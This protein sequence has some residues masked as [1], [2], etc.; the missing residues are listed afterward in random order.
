MH[1]A[2]ALLSP[3]VGLGL[4]AVTG[5]ALVISARKLKPEL[6]NN[7]SL[8]ALMGVLGAFVFAAEMV[9]FSIPGT[10][11]SGHLGGAM[12]LAIIL[13]PWAGFVV[14]ASFLLIQALFFGDGGL[15]AWGANA[16]NLG[17][18]SCFV[19]YPL[20][21]RPLAGDGSQRKRVTLAVI[22][23]CTLSMA[24]AALGVTVETELSGITTIPF[25]PFMMLMVPVHLVIGLVE[26]V[27]TAAILSY[28]ARTQPDLLQRQSMP[29][30]PWRSGRTLM[31]G[32][33]LAAVLTGG[34]LTWFSSRA[35]EG[36]EWALNGMGHAKA[37]EVAA[38]DGLKSQLAHIQSSMTLFDGTPVPGGEG[39]VSPASSFEGLT[40]SA[41]TLG[42][43]LA[44]G[45][46][47]RWRRRQK[48][49]RS[50]GHS[51]Q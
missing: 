43:V 37:L 36:V 28:V 8:M 7:P 5:V 20:V 14:V 51:S 25:M 1:M 32:F 18:M 31:G 3:A 33:L 29:A 38:G 46:L 9:N 24:S 45:L 11:S 16:F 27:I 44:V 21:Y 13:G 49:T 19:I 10:G 2:D 35:P 12:L 50:N 23:S 47:L 6:Q 48:F 41:L 26:G 39:I 4:Y 34:V 42:L 22:V 30:T 17:V 15:L 40:G